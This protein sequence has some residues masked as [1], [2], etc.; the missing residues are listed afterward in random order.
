MRANRKKQERAAT[1][2]GWANAKKQALQKLDGAIENEETDEKILP[3]LRKINSRREYYTTSSCAGRIALIELKKFGAKDNSNFIGRW[4]GT[5]A[6]GEF[7]KS[8]EEIG[9]TQTWL[10]VEPPILH[11]KCENMGAAKEL[12]DTAY[13]SGFK[14]SAIKSLRSGALVEIGSSERMELPVA[15]DGKR[16]ASADYLRAAMKIANEKLKKSQAKLKI[17][18]TAL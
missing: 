5:A 13:T 18:E 17:L 3:L 9:K 14:Y 10:K 7:A 2:N 15:V 8:L 1:C 4:H 6:W 12:L 11:V 16:I